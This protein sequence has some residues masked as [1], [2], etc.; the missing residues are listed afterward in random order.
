MR[1]VLRRGEQVVLKTDGR[2]G[3]V[4]GEA[5]AFLGR[6]RLIRVLWDGRPETHYEYRRVDELEM[7]EIAG[8]R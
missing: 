3:E 4:L 5:P 2:T 1:A 8:N 6:D 7:P